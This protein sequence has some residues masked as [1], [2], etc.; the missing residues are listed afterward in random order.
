MRSYVYMYRGKHKYDSQ[1]SNDKKFN[2][3]IENHQK[4]DGTKRVTLKYSSFKGESIS[5]EVVRKYTWKLVIQI[6]VGYM[7]ILK[8]DIQRKEY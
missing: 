1:K 2:D 4:Y 7:S 6:K 5:R 3:W 8:C